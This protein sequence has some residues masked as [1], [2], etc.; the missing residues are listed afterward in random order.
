M[1]LQ[2]EESTPKELQAVALVKLFQNCKLKQEI[3][4]KKN[5][6]AKKNTTFYKLFTFRLMISLC[7]SP[8]RLEGPIPHV[9][10]IWVCMWDLHS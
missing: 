2:I 5:Q 1:S 10:A 8:N 4:L 9:S 3:I 6:W 7:W